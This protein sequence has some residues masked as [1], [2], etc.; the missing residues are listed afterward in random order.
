MTD[1]KQLKEAVED[2]KSDPSEADV[3][4]DSEVQHSDIPELL[5]IIPM[6]ELNL[7][8]KMIHPM[9]IMD[10][11]LM[12]VVQ[13]N[14]LKGRMVG[15]LALKSLNV[16]PG[17][18][19]MNDLH[20]IGVAAYVL[21]MS[22]GDDGAMRVLT[23]GL[24]RI[25]LLELVET[26]PYMVGRIQVI[27]ESVDVDREVE[28]LMVNIRGLFKQVLDMSPGMP[29]E[30]MGMNQNI[31]EPGLLSDMIISA[32]NIDKDEKLELLA[33]ID[34]KKRMEKV[35]IVLE[36]QLEIL[37]LGSKIQSRIKGK[38]DKS[39]KEYYL[40]EQLKAI[41]AE[42]GDTDDA[43][44]EL[45]DL[46]KRLDEKNL[47]DNVRKAADK[48]LDRLR[49]MNPASAEYS[50]ARTYLDWII[51]LPWRDEAEETIDIQEARKILEED[52]FD[53]EKVKK[54]IIEYLAVRKLK[55]DMK[56]PILCFAG[57]PGTGKTS[58]GKSIARALGREFV[59]VSLGGVRD[60]AE[61]R[62]H[63]RTYVGA[64]PGRIIQG[65]KRAGTTNPVFMLDEVD[66][67]GGDF[68]G[69]PS[70]ALL[71]VL[72]PEQNHAFSDH[73]MEVD[74][75][76]SKV[77]FIGTANVLDNIPAPLRDRM[78]I[79]TL[80]GYTNEEKLL[81]AKKYLVPRQREAHGLK[82]RDIRFSDAAVK[83]IISD[84]TR[85][86]GLRNLEREIGSV[87]RYA[88]TRVAE[89]DADKIAINAANVP[90]ILGPARFESE[91]RARTAPA[92][93]ATGMAWTQ[94]GGDI[95]FIEATSMPGKGGLML[96]GQ[97]G[98]VM[99][100]SAQTALSCIR[101]RSEKLKLEDDFFAHRDIHVH[102]PAGAIPK[103]GP[104]AGVTMATALLSMA[105]KRPVKPDVAM[106]GE[107]TL[108]GLVLPVG[109]IKEKVLAAKRAGIKSIILP[110]RNERDFEEISERL[111]EGL[112]IYP[113]ETIDEVWDLALK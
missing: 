38:I 6:A 8:P 106:T 60:E 90:D 86:A 18:I 42:L 30:L 40:R 27:N 103:D 13:D 89:G 87:C 100:E 5:P 26:D 19:G 15:L 48:E 61:I 28:A 45:E 107:I 7:F 94:A 53:L 80:S 105:T 24:K 32:L 75:D 17:E 79:I 44:I 96:T 22:M 55:P 78:E 110:K 62:G 93:V 109:G 102:V 2:R 104:S 33:E 37:E 14:L 50:V 63:R 65:M 101:S 47:P 66:K 97:L 111:R 84:Y 49:R 77:V 20:P 70:S 88:A 72:D 12:A 85:E 67:L 71:E 69:D 31:K 59:R 74:Y 10:P 83:T 68:R 3:G 98:D 35:L 95:L 99:R 25:R 51:D 73:Y 91:V 81:I 52:H 29:S 1:D 56:G 21:K 57:P 92:G 54:R 41:Q 36:E 34:I 46:K 4:R 64:L 11:G 39:Q 16:K 43:D 9:V 76:L 108:R 82:A 113:V 23:Q 58:L 112:Q